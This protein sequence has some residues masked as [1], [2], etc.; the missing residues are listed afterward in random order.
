MHARFAEPGSD[1]LALLTL[2]DYLRER[3]RELSG[4]GVPPDVPPR[5]PALPAGAR[6]AGRLRPAAAG[7]QGPRHRASAADRGPPEPAAAAAPADPA[8]RPV[9]STVR[10]HRPGDA[11]PARR[12][13]RRG[14][15][16]TLADRVH[17]S[18]LAG[19]LSHIGMQ[20]AEQQPRRRS[21]AGRAEFAGARGARFAI[22]PDSALAQEAAAV[23]GG[24]RAG[25]DVPAVGQGGGAHR[26]RVGRAAGR[27]PGQAQL[28]RA[29]L[30]RPAR[31]G[32]GAGEGDPVRPADRGRAAGQLRAR[33]TRRR[34]G[35]CSSRTRWSRATGRPTTRSSHRNQRL[36]GRGRGAGATRPGGAASSPTTR[37]CSTSTTGGSRQDVTSARHFDSWWKKARAGRPR[38]ADAHRRR[39]GRARPPSQIQPG[40]LPRAR[41]A[42]C[43][44]RM[45]SRRASRTTA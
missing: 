23:G 17:Q 1:F 2:W 22:F 26:A 21:G 34:P 14:S 24:R 7:G 19:L 4:V 43:R 31:R 28:Q 11:R 35:S 6:V 9:R 30:G 16:R 27:A 18:L 20:D 41:G 39:P 5:V 33:S 15:R 36:L 13:R 8:R 37:R 44:C 42:S 40:R 25:R 12:S 45:S 10:K 3:Q 38:P 32:D 29:A